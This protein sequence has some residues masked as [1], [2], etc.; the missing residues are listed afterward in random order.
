MCD[1]TVADQLTG[2]IEITPEMIE[3]GVYEAREH[4]LG[5]PLSDLVRK[6]F[7]AMT[8]EARQ[9]LIR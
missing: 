6:V 1:A 5:A 2:K 8:V 9:T 3:A 7:I 4:F